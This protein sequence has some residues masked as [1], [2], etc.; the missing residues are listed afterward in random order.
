MEDI[1][2]YYIE[3]K[4]EDIEDQNLIN[5]LHSNVIS[6]APLYY[7][8]ETIPTIL[9]IVEKNLHNENWRCRLRALSFF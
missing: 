7:T 4:E 6:L 2:S 8:P 1:L 5:E 3:F 9:R